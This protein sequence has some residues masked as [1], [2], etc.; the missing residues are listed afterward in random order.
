MR[1]MD[2]QTALGQGKDSDPHTVDTVPRALY[3]RPVLYVG[4]GQ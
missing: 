1:Q 3:K 4:R 2:G